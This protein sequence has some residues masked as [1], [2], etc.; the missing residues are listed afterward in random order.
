M[1]TTRTATSPKKPT[2]PTKIATKASAAKPPAKPAPKA[3]AAK[4][5][6]K[7]A[8]QVSAAKPAAKP[9]RT[10]VVVAVPEA[11]P[12]AEVIA[13]PASRPRRRGRSARPVLPVA[14]GSLTQPGARAGDSCERCGT[15][16]VT[17][18]ALVL[19]DG[20][21]VRFTSCHACEHRTWLGPNG[22]LDR[23]T[24]LERTRKIR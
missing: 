4:P 17:S 10:R 2:T 19:T 14:L 12:L 1:A 3:S 6:P 24:V 22:P 7:V 16:R 8:P 5:T 21:P 23:T 18:L 11:A 15:E 9:R 13:L 20:T